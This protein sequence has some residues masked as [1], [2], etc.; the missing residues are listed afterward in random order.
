M[1]RQKKQPLV[2]MSLEQMRE[3]VAAADSIEGYRTQLG[4]LAEK[5]ATGQVNWTALPLF[6]L[7][8]NEAFAKFRGATLPSTHRDRAPEQSATP[9]PDATKASSGEQHTVQAPG[10]PPVTGNL[11]FLC[12]HFGK[13]YGRTYQRFKQQGD[14]S[15]E[16]ALELV[17]RQPR[18]RP[19]GPFSGA[20]SNQ[21]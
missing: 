12:R 9:E 6:M 1:S 8:M 14:W 10:S 11:A 7:A 17:K 13:D 19:N 16:E 20:R 4:Q 18:E 5:L 2:A 21:A 15:L 3:I